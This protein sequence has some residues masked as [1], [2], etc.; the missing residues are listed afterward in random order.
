MK[1]YPKIYPPFKRSDDGRTLDTSTFFSAELEALADAPGWR[2]S[3]KIDGTNIRIHWDGH[4]VTVGGRTD[5]A[6]LYPPLITAVC[7]LYTEELFEEFHG[8]NTVTLY[9]EGVGP[10]IQN[11]FKYSP[12]STVMLFDVLV[13]DDR[14]PSGG[15]WLGP[16]AVAGIAAQFKGTAAHQLGTFS[17]TEAVKTVAGGMPSGYGDF[18]AEGMVGVAP[19]GLLNRAGERITVKVKGKDFA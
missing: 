17:L 10:K 15:W 4:E 7:D 19:A 1:L 11:G 5:K 16:E 2:W 8:G 12:T 13:A 18:I 6:V 14:H 3:E 9:G